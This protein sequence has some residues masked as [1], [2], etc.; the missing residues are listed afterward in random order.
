M[1]SNKKSEHSI[2]SKDIKYSKGVG[3]KYAE[4]LAKKN[5]RAVYD[6]LTFFPRDYDDRTKLVPINEA[7][8]NGDKTSVVSVEI[9]NVSTFTF[10]FRKKPLIII[11]DGVGIAEIPIYGGRLPKFV[12][13]GKKIIVTGKFVRSSRGKAQCR[14][15]EMEEPSAEPL[16]YGKIVP[17]YP[18]TE[19]LSQKKLRLLILQEIEIFR[20]NISYD[21]PKP[22][23]KKYKMSFIDAVTQMHYPSSFELLEQAKNTL[24]FE[25]FLA[26]QYI[27]LSDKRP[28]I[29]TKKMRYKDPGLVEKVKQT[30]PYKLTDDQEKTLLEITNTLLS[31]K[32]LFALLQG[33]VG[34]GKTIVAF[35]ASIIVCSSGY[36]AAMLAPTE[37]L[38]KQHY[39][40]IKNIIKK[41]GINITVDCLS[42]SLTEAER[43]YVLK[44]LYEGRTD[45]IV[46]THSLLND[47]VVFKNL[48]YVVVDEQQRFGTQQRDAL[49]YKGENV[50]YLLMTATPIPQSLAMTIFGELDTLTI[51]TM[52]SSRKT[53]KTKIMGKHERD[54]S[55]RFLQSRIKKGEQGYVIFPFIEETEN[56]Y[57]NLTGE[58]KRAKE[59]YFSE[60]E[61]A[62]LHGKMK[63]EEKNYLM[64]RFS[65]NEIK[66]LFSTSVIEVGIDNPNAT[67]ILI[68]GAE[69]FGLSQ[70]H[71]MRGRVGRGDK[72]GY[73]YLMLHSETN[74]IIEERLG[75]I[76]ETTDGFRI[77]EKDLDLRGSGEFLGTRQSGMPD[78]KLGKITKDVEIMRF[79]QSE[80]R[81]LLSDEN[82]KINFLEKNPN[83]KIRIEY[84][85]TSLD[86]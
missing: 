73:C 80:M 34:S 11:T 24:V 39:E 36:Q 52:P 48:G 70:L 1:D 21:I 83:F 28:N 43:G 46:G 18:L 77:A 16:S 63:D 67:T 74:E 47:E 20:K 62:M 57:I 86:Y 6:L 13:K 38:V 37:I 26:F 17:I 5:I 10:Q 68:E 30:L 64:E 41:S 15:I 19:G 14:L 31:T 23:D 33:D 75:I 76:T 53:V 45:I 32:Q 84:L 78:F 66:I 56:S 35:L 51:K 55:Y 59:T 9:V 40:T 25:E 65:K 81:A 7:L 54:H 29:L 69:R 72:E 49:L 4:I 42:S 60:I 2:F 61:T 79:A 12:E 85:K 8:R 50:D 71:Q 44:R 82:R 3:A 27:H 22:Y 58:Y